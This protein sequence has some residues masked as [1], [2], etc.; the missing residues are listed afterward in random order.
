MLL[1]IRI[2]NCARHIQKH[3]MHA[4][5]GKF[6]QGMNEYDNNY[7]Y[8]KNPPSTDTFTSWRHVLRCTNSYTS[9]GRLLRGSSKSD[10]NF[11]PV[12]TV[13]HPSFAVT[14]MLRISSTEISNQTVSF[15]SFAPYFIRPLYGIATPLNHTHPDI[16]LHDDC[17]VKIGDFGLA[18]VKTRWR[19]GEKVRQPTGSILWMVSLIASLIK[20]LWN[21]LTMHTLGTHPL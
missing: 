8:L 1:I 12:F 14:Y 10:S 17:T 2:Y 6:L 21:L 15:E 4:L 18:T 16:F 11:V 9:L 5:S 13:S 7:I 20:T 19:E 3:C